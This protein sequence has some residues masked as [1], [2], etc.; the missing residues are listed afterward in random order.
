MT[1]A[2][3][4]FAAAPRQTPP[5]TLGQAPRAAVVIAGRVD[6][7]SAHGASLD[8]QI[9]AH[10]VRR[11]AHRQT[12][13]DR[14]RQAAI[15]GE[16][17][18]LGPHRPSLRRGLRGL[19]AVSAVPAVA[20]ELAIH[21]GPVPAEPSSRHLN[22]DPR[23]AHRLDP[24]AFLATEPLCHTKNLHR[25][26]IDFNNRPSWPTCRIHR[27]SSPTNNPDA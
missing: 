13:R 26:D 11:P 24:G 20:V 6:C 4:A 22:A 14:R 5:R 19:R 15:G 3:F 10:R 18:R 2:L 21:S 25:L 27:W 12:L 17:G 9:R 7:L 8:A 16:L 1:S 23:G